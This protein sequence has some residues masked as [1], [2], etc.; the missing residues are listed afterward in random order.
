MKHSTLALLIPLAV[1]A[2]TGGERTNPAAGR[3]LSLAGAEGAPAPAV[4]SDVERGNMKAKVAP[5]RRQVKR[6]TAGTPA[7]VATPAP[8]VAEVQTEPVTVASTPAEPAAE[9]AAAPQPLPSAGGIGTPLAA[10]ETVT[11]VPAVSMGGGVHGGRGDIDVGRRG[12]SGAI[13]G[14]D[15]DN[16]APSRG[17]VIAV[18]RP[19]VSIRRF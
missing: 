4:L 9:A 2:C 6:S 14:I 16:C 7:A 17:P 1:A 15:H 3:D 19:Y 10:G 12:G 5:A 18:N 8:D 13:I 11:I